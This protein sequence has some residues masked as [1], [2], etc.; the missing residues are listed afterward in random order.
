M[1]RRTRRSS[2]VTL[3]P[4]GEPTRLSLALLIGVVLAFAAPHVASG[5]DEEASGVAVPP[6]IT[7]WYGGDQSFGSIGV[8][9]RDANILG[10]VSG[11]LSSLTYSLNG[12]ASRNLSTGPDTRRL[13]RSGDF[14]IDLTYAGL[15]P[16]LNSIQISAMSTGGELTQTTV[17]VRDLSGSPWS[18]PYSVDWS[19]TSSLSDSAQVVDGKWGVTPDGVRVL[20][21]GYDRL[22]AIGDTSWTDYEVTAEVTVHGIDSTAEA[23]QAISGGPGVG[24]IM[25]WEGHTNE[26][27]Y[28]PP[29]DQPRSGY[30]PLGAI[31]WYHWRTGFGNTDPNQWE[32]MGDDLAMKAQNGAL[33]LQYGVRYLFKMQVKTVAGLGGLYRFKV[34]ESSGVEPSSWLLTGQETLANPQQGSLLLV[35]HHAYVTFGS[36]VVTPVPDE[37]PPVLSNI[38][39]VA[40]AT[41]A[42]ITWTT[43]EPATSRVSYGLSQSYGNMVINDE[44]VLDHAA[45]LTGLLP[46]QTY[47]FKVI[48]TD[49]GGNA[50]SSNDSTF[51]TL[52]LPLPPAPLALLPADGATAL[53]GTIQFIWGSA[54]NAEFYRLQV[55]TDPA[56]GTGLVLDDSTLMDT[57]WTVEGLQEGTA[58]YWRV[59]GKNASGSG[60]YSS[61]RSFSTGISAPILVSPA[62]GATQQP[63][64]LALRW[65]S[66]TGATS[67]HVQVATDSGFTG[68]FV[69]DDPNVIDTVRSVS[70]LLNGTGYYWR[71]RGRNGLT[72]GAFSTAWSFSTGLSVPILAAPL[73]GSST[74]PEGVLLRW[75][76]VQD[77]STYHV[78][79]ATDPSF[80]S[81]VIL[82]DPSVVDSQKAVTG[83]TNGNRYYWRVSARN[84]GGPGP[85][86]G[87][88]SFMT[89]FP[90]PVLASPPNNAQGQPLSLTFAWMGV[91]G[92]DAY[93]FQLATDPSFGTGIVK[94]DSSVVDTSRVVHGLVYGETY[95]WRVRAKSGTI[96]GGHSPVWAFTCTGLVPSPVLLV[97]LPGGISHSA[98]TALFVWRSGQPDVD[99][100][101]FEIAPDSQFVFRLVDS[102]LTDTATVVASLLDGKRYWWRVR[103]HN[104]EGWGP[105]SETRSFAVILTDIAEGRGVP[106]HFSLAQN[107]PNPFNPSTV[108]Q[109]QLPTET[110]V[111]L[112][113][114]NLLGER[115]ATLVNEVRPAGLYRE[116]F[117][118]DGLP[119]GSY[120]YRISTRGGTLTRKMLLVK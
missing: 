51:Q 109:F 63:S 101:W 36:V 72:S 3:L 30:L 22:I 68:G 12:G 31:G 10:H 81:G 76:R 17:L 95:Y 91:E 34:W 100:Y 4:R 74:D 29:I 86:S 21:A 47:H 84:G 55:G 83:L 116:R 23:F 78:Q 33:Q 88:W 90:G 80:S 24:L 102:T 9:Q 38:Q 106:E 115:V 70:G 11:S 8:P 61:L 58:H 69:L 65:Q 108:I 16:G 114:F 46:E 44:L 82:D 19:S 120:I 110:E 66:L 54:E 27:V 107:F 42:I 113:V 18:F 48:S 92:A 85:P 60:P 64:N 50:S 99:R 104:D 111:R 103:A 2:R 98:D 118:A 71:V 97:S 53:P 20:E 52:P 40:S 96:L 14:N 112:E 39:S 87:V 89:T 93:L 75:N 13:S 56:F 41:G 67:Y 77:A 49:Y 117:H 15:L 25:R 45:E 94:S 119:S 59:R 37:V 62:D 105:Y 43:D 79:L 73:D 57:T 5:Q 6:S 26:P 1:N 28:D 35:A 7:L 32:L